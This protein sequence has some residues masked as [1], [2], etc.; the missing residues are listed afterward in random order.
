M[1]TSN[2]EFYRV[3]NFVKNKEDNVVYQSETLYAPKEIKSIEKG[4]ALTDISNVSVDNTYN[5]RLSLLYRDVENKYFIYKLYVVTEGYLDEQF[6]INDVLG[7]SNLKYVTDADNSSLPIVKI[8]KSVGWGDSDFTSY[9]SNINGNNMQIVIT[10]DA[11]SSEN[12]NTYYTIYYL[13]KMD[14][15]SSG[16][17]TSINTASITINDKTVSDTAEVV[18]L[19]EQIYPGIQKSFQGVYFDNTTQKDE[20]GY[21]PRLTLGATEGSHM[22]WKVSITN[23]K[24]TNAKTMTNYTIQDVLPALYNYDDTYKDNSSTVAKYYPS[25][26]IYDENGAVV[27]TIKAYD[28]ATSGYNTSFM[29]PE[30]SSITEDNKQKSLLK[31]T[32]NGEE[33]KLE[34]GYKMEITF[35]TKI[36]TPT[37]GKFINNAYLTIE[38]GFV[39]SNVCNGTVKYFNGEKAIHALDSITTY[40]AIITTSYKE[41]ETLY[42]NTNPLYDYAISNNQSDRIMKGQIGEQVKYTLNIENNSEDTMKKLVIIDRLPYVGDKYALTNDNRDS[43]FSIKYNNI[44]NIKFY[45]VNTET[46][47]ETEV[48]LVNGVDYKL[49]YSNEKSTG[50]NSESSDWIGQDGITT[51][52]ENYQEDDVNV[53]ITFSDNLYI[54]PSERIVAELLATIPTG[55]KIESS[56][57]DN[58][59]WNN[60]GYCYTAVK[61]EDNSQ[62]ISE[63]IVA[64]SS[65]VGV[66]VEE[67]LTKLKFTKSWNDNDNSHN[68]RPTS[69]Q[70]QLQKR[71]EGEAEYTNVG[72]PITIDA[73]IYQSANNSNEWIYTFE[74]LPKYES[75]KKVE[76]TVIE[77]STSSNYEKS[78][79]EIIQTDDEFTVKIENTEIT[80][81][82]KVN[83]KV[84]YNE[85]DISNNIDRTFYFV[86]KMSGNRYVLHDD[87]ENTYIDTIT[88][89]VGSNKLSDALWEINPKTN[90]VVE[91]TGLILGDSYQVIEVTENGEII[92]GNNSNY[93][94]SYSSSS[95]TI[96]NSEVIP[97]V[98]I[99]NSVKTKNLEVIKIWND[100]V[101]T[102]HRPES[103]EVILYA[104]SNIAKDIYGNEM[105]VTLTNSN[106]TDSYTWKYTFNNLPILDKNGNEI[107]YTIV[108][109]FDSD[110]Y[111]QIVSGMTITNDFVVPDD[112]I[113]ITVNKKWESEESYI[114]DAIT[115]VLNEYIDDNLTNT[116]EVIISK[117][118]CDISN[119]GTWTY[120]IENLPKYDSST[121]KEI[122]YEVVEQKIN[123]FEV[124]VEDEN[125]EGDNKSI[126]I[127][128]VLKKGN[129]TVVKTVKSA[130]DEDI[131]NE[132]TASYYFIVK[133]GSKYLNTNGELQD[134]PVIFTITTGGNSEHRV[135]IQNVLLDKEYTVIETDI[136]G[137]T[138]GNSTEDYNILYSES[139]TVTITEAN[140]NGN[141]EIINKLIN[142]K[143]V[144]T[145][146]WNDNDNFHNIRPTSIQIQLQKRL[147]G[148]TN[149][150]NVGDPVT[151]EAS[152]HQSQDNLNEWIYTFEDLPKYENGKKIEYNVIEVAGSSNYTQS[153]G[154]IV[155]TEDGYK[156]TIENTEQVGI[157]RV[158]KKVKY[159][160]ED[161]SNN[162]DKSFYFVV[163][164]SGNRYV[165]HDEQGNTYIDT[166]EELTGSD[167]LDKAL[168][169][170]NPK[171]TNGVRITNL[172][173]NEQYEVVEVNSN[174]ETMNE[175]NSNYN[176]SYSSKGV[177][178]T[179]PGEVPEITITN[180]VKTRSLEIIKRWNDSQNTSHR[181]ESIVVTL[182]ANSNVATDING[183]RLENIEIKNTNATDNYTW[184]YT[185]NDL[186]ILDK[187]GN[188]ITYTISENSSYDFYSQSIDGLT[189]TNNF[190]TKVEYRELNITK[191]WDN[192]GNENE[193]NFR[194]ES[195]MFIIV[196]TD[197]NEEVR[198]VTVNK[199][200]DWKYSCSDLLKYNE[201]GFEIEYKVYEVV[202]DSIYYTNKG[203]ID[204]NGEKVIEAVTQNKV[205]YEITNT[206]EIPDD[207]V[208][209]TVNKM[210]EAQESY[211]P[212]SII[213]TLKGYVDNQAISTQDITINRNSCIIDNDGT[214]IYVIN[215]LP[216]YD[217]VTGKEITYEIIEKEISN[218]ETHIINKNFAGENKY[219][220]L[221][222]VLKTGSL[223]IKKTVKNANSENISNT[224]NS[225][226][227]FVVKSEDKYLN[228]NGELQD[229]KEVFTIATG[230]NSI[231]AVTIENVYLDK[232]YTV[233]ETDSEGNEFVNI[234]KDYDVSY[235]P[236]GGN[237]TITGENPDGNVE[238]VNKLKTTQITINKVWNDGNDEYQMRPNSIKVKL[239]TIKQ[240][241]EKTEEITIVKA[242]CEIVDNNWIYVIKDLPNY[243]DYGNRITYR[244]EEISVLDWYYQS[245]EITEKQEGINYEFTVTNSEILGEYSLTLRKVDENNNPILG[246]N[247]DINGESY[248]TDENGEVVVVDSEEIFNDEIE[249]LTIN[250]IS[251]TG[252]YGQKKYIKISEPISLYIAKDRQNNDLKVTG[253]SFDKDTNYEQTINKYV[254]LENGQKVLISAEIKDDQISIV[255]PNI[256]QK[257]D[258][259]LKKFITKVDDNNLGSRQPE[260]IKDSNGQYTYKENDEVVSVENNNL[261]TYTIR[262]Y[263][264]GNSHGY[265][266]VIED[267]IPDGLEFV[268]DN[269]I[270]KQ[271]KW[272]M[273]NDKNQ[274]T[275][276]YQE[277][278]KI[279]T[280]YLS[281]EKG[282]VANLIRAFDEE[283][284]DEP[285]YKDIQVVFRVKEPKSIDRIVENKAQIVEA[286]DYDNKSAKDIDST[287]NVWIN[288]EDDQD[289]EKVRVKYFDL[290]LSKYATKT[291]VVRNGK[292]E[293]VHTGNGDGKEKIAKVDIK[294]SEIDNVVVKL[295]YLIKVTNEGEIPGYAKE[296]T[297]Y[298]PEGLEFVSEDNPLWKEENGKVTTESLADTL[299]MP[300]ES[301]EVTIKLTWVN[302]EN[303]MGLKTNIAEISKDSNEYD[304]PDIDSTPNNMNLDE[305][306]TDDSQIMITTTTGQIVIYVVLTISVLGILVVGIIVVKKAL[307]K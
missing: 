72:D 249:E 237:I 69:I 104:G 77:V 122:R 95:V 70:I 273:I 18:V 254:Q 192:K 6:T 296:I 90:A 264:E 13:V 30:I 15:N 189:I 222:N 202:L 270:N 303:N 5:D 204:L 19:E 166:I 124:Q 207:K 42:D 268:E 55:E 259:S 297:D 148:E 288:G 157:I 47:E 78:E 137:T 182:Y 173:L 191:I 248:T 195:I 142:K 265:A 87:E 117:N 266:T 212:N 299:L 241:G 246:V 151:L 125:Y 97:E 267:D 199:D 54:N 287:P 146:K 134:N 65:Q 85:E 167:K 238:I 74:D 38:E 67:Q 183:N 295:E 108:E 41:V 256:E 261:V 231:H 229:E 53:R 180:S 25:I 160:E 221:K 232:K 205:D 258:M 242:D 60:F 285:D 91:L 154:Q 149:Y 220:T 257:F 291:I 36:D 73:S 49:E 188:E 129:L 240:D 112:K 223:T 152:K 216:K 181:P 52:H 150:V 172:I 48:T 300:G 170:V 305:D 3:T 161:I 63:N 118:S 277:A 62:I 66:W 234:T 120:V 11:D 251:Y 307:V 119:D 123:N 81:N 80:G 158:N 306:D 50:F 23:S 233:I 20:D 193:E 239:H 121:G 290:S 96:E 263:N 83:K 116:R 272:K 35:S 219:I 206:F 284:M 79:P 84:K 10:P 260:F 271:Y 215:N 159:N 93:S 217:S 298:I 45:K 156:V 280:P 243:D 89:L 293:V 147:Q 143:L 113:K 126:T 33:Y 21:N 286:R 201:N 253:I 9:T 59:A 302:G 185:F 139:D 56:G 163:K 22:V 12:K 178:I 110:F 28:E 14:E 276:D 244:V 228:T 187:N 1:K 99:T 57:E 175:N 106:A 111:S 179:N 17:I 304:T 37:A 114:P 168:W 262:V 294:T 214:W 252:D 115:V 174:G 218:F 274:I 46:K 16:N 186:P 27:K 292:E 171:N 32:F 145:K 153:I 211:I 213:V 155:E 8:T 190:T 138:L 162:I 209:I 279:W 269:E 236:E 4:V 130:Y 103:I 255:I 136:N 196:R 131:T 225:K 109:N 51:W 226:Y 208:K 34:P 275:E 245:K 40:S 82:I 282:G 144:V 140:P 194:P 105:K 197:T 71:L 43:K 26:V 230:T 64:E 98:T 203:V 100:S 88:S 169:E 92:N 102:E 200:T 101:N 198:R 2:T 61:Y 24:A 283:T 164:M 132:M 247:F 68:V 278:V 250:E 165:L 39:D 133:S 184:K 44:D 29:E 281:K 227:Y 141:V 177:T 94:V 107:T 58:I 235:S 135:T 7:N 76:Y 127:K 86:V 289:T 301:A 75:G 31:W 176:V 210:W 128:N 224:I